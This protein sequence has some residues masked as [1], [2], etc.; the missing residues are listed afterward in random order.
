MMQI[1]NT[2]EEEGKEEME[3]GGWIWDYV[4]FGSRRFS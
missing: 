3:V 4:D 2:K 1:S